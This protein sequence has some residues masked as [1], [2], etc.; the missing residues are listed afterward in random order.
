[1]MEIAEIAVFSR[2]CV[3]ATDSFFPLVINTSIVPEDVPASRACGAVFCS[4]MDVTA[5]AA[6]VR[7]TVT[8]LRGWY[9]DDMP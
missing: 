7:Y 6:E 1:M 5:V 8:K 9:V 2:H 3:A 4:A